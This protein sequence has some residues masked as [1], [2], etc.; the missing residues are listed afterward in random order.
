MHCGC[1]KPCDTTIY[2][3]F[4][5]NRKP[6]KREDQPYSKIYIY[7]TSKMVSI[8]EER[9]SYDS[10]QF[11]ADLGGSLGFLLGLS[12]IG[13]IIFLEKILGYFFLDKFAE[14]LKQKKKKV[15]TNAE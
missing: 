7:Y 12:V 8:L 15:D 10:S 4:V 14:D 2:S 1:L 9:S 11:I 3:S 13:F 5:M 6:M